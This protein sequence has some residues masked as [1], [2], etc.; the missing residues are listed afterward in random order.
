MRLSATPLLAAF[1]GLALAA[2]A[3]S[4]HAAGHTGNHRDIE[5]TQSNA[6]RHGWQWVMSSTEAGV[7]KGAG[8]WPTITVHVGDE[9]TFTGQTAPGHWFGLSAS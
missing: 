5:I 8:S 2:S 9:I 3:P 1:A 6:D 4:V 7:V